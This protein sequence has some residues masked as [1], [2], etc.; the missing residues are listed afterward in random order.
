[1]VLN[2]NYLKREKHLL[3][4]C[5]SNSLDRY[6]GQKDSRYVCSVNVVGRGA[7]DMEIYK[8]AKARNLIIITK[9]LKFEYFLMDKNHPSIFRAHGRDVVMEQIRIRDQVTDSLLRDD[10]IIIP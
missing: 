2:L 8:Y 5:I 4:S 3:I 10:K 1:M 7:T 9:D 6:A